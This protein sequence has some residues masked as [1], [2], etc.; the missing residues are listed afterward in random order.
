MGLGLLLLLLQ[1][2]PAPVPSIFIYY[3]LPGAANWTYKSVKLD[4][5]LMF[6][7][8]ATGQA[9]LSAYVVSGPMGPQGPPGKD[10]AYA[11]GLGFVTIDNPPYPKQVNIDTNYSAFRTDPPAGPGICTGLAVGQAASTRTWAA[12]NTG[13]YMC[14]VN[15]DATGFIWMKVPGVTNW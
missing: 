9:H 7:V 10:A 1:A 4:P 11:F 8:D 13:I 12:D 2:T 6:S 14:V 3:A 5:P 15:D